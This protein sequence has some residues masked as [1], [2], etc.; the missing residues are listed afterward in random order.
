MSVRGWQFTGSNTY[1]PKM[2]RITARN[3]GYTMG[4]LD[5]N[6]LEFEGRKVF[7]DYKEPMVVTYM[8]VPVDEATNRE[9]FPQV[10][11][12]YEKVKQEYSLGNTD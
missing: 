8:V 10:I 2:V 6:D 3:K 11:P 4:D 1:N 9:Y 12:R 7:K 5:I